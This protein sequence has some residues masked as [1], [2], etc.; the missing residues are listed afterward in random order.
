VCPSSRIE[1]DAVRAICPSGLNPVYH[2]SFPIP[3]YSVRAYGMRRSYSRL[4]KVD[5]CTGFLSLCLARLF[6]VLERFRTIDYVLSDCGCTDIFETV[7]TMWFPDAQQVE[8]GTINNE[9][10]FLAVKHGA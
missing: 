7:L 5:E 8:V 3:V 10:R 6:D 1:D 9:D 4:E 2:R